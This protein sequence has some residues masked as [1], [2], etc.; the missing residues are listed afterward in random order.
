MNTPF[1]GAVDMLIHMNGK[2]TKA[3][4]KSPLCRNVYR[5]KRVIR[6]RKPKKDGHYNKKKR[7]NNDLQ[8]I[9]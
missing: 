8:N 1:A 6:S 9:T 4:L 7:T 3:K 2:F 5:Y